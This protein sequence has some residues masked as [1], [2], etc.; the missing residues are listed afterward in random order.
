[1]A[2][3]E[4]SPLV[5]AR[6]SFEA[7]MARARLRLPRN[8]S[9]DGPYS[10]WGVCATDDDFAILG[11]QAFAHVRFLSA[12]M[13]FGAVLA[14]LGLL[15]MTSGQNPDRVNEAGTA[16][17]WAEL[18]W[19]HVFC[20][21]A[22]TLV[23]IMFVVREQVL[24]MQPNFYED[25]P[26]EKA[27]NGAIRPFRAISRGAQNSVAD[28]LERAMEGKSAVWAPSGSIKEEIKS[29]AAIE[30]VGKDLHGSHLVEACSLV[31]SG[32]GAGQPPPPQLLQAIRDA[33]GC[34][35]VA[36]V[37]PHECF[38]LEAAL[39]ARDD[40]ALAFEEAKAKAGGAGAYTDHRTAKALAR[41]EAAQAALD[42]IRA[43]P[44]KLLDYVFVTLPHSRAK[45][46]VLE[47]AREGTLLKDGESLY[48]L[49]A[50][51]PRD[52]L[53]HNLG[54]TH[55]QR[56]RSN[57]LV[58][59]VMTP[60][61]LLNGTFVAF[62]VL[63]MTL[64]HTSPL[65]LAPL[66]TYP[67][68]FGCFLVL[69]VLTMLSIQ[70][71]I[72]PLFATFAGRGLFGNPNIRMMACTHTT[73]HAKVGV[74]A[75]WFE[76]IIAAG[77]FCF[78]IFLTTGESPA[79]HHAGKRF[80]EWLALTFNQ[81]IVGIDFYKMYGSEAAQNIVVA[82]FAQCLFLAWLLPAASQY[83]MAPFSKSQKMMDQR[84]RILA[85]HV[86][87]FTI[88][89]S[90]RI[91]AVCMV[92]SSV[93]PAQLF[94]LPGYVL[95][96][97]FVSRSNLLGRIEPGAPTKPLLY[98]IAFS[99]YLPFHMI[100][101]FIYVMQIYMDIPLRHPNID[102]VGPFGL[103][104]WN[105]STPKAF[106]FVF[107]CVALAFVLVAIPYLHRQQALK[108]GLLTPWQLF[109]L[110]C[111]IGADDPHFLLSGEVTEGLHHIPAADQAIVELPATL[112]RGAFYHGVAP[113]YDSLL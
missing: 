72:Q 100:L 23:F 17:G 81:D 86:L 60:I 56:K 35:P 54:S 49:P 104:A 57:F 52:V 8:P 106:H 9:T 16:A 2:P 37:Q 29:G 69:F 62:L 63:P 94:V 80:S 83:L 32:W 59:A 99:V 19:L 34:D 90:V 14:L 103:N 109:K 96:Q 92:F 36:A 105:S 73:L 53:W 113:T 93:F 50:P 48:V 22:V 97:S 27:V 42:A 82:A 101:R 5:A 38:D 64:L 78:Y 110:S 74:L 43:A 66:S 3:S 70:M 84:C 40:A 39:E 1:M 12:S 89:D 61:A 51:N 55:A 45:A 75:L 25:K 71:Y 21:I 65:E 102:P 6:P 77:I 91:L 31:V 85:P 24:L 47:A 68:R 76:F 11:S 67:Y 30:D 87:P 79:I 98:R 111:F 7:A 26:F 33:A 46:Q 20:D 107:T 41:L 15:L 10:L 28:K 13:K 88:T 112:P 18:S 4:A 44:P 108:L 95:A 58:L